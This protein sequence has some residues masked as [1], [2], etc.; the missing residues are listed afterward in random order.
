MVI[1]SLCPWPAVL[2]GGDY[3]SSY[4][5]YNPLYV[6]GPGLNTILRP[7]SHISRVHCPEHSSAPAIDVWLEPNIPNVSLVAVLKSCLEDLNLLVQ[8]IPI[9]LVCQTSM[10]L[11]ISFSLRS[12]EVATWRSARFT[13]LVSGRLSG[14]DDLDI[15]LYD[16]SCYFDIIREKMARF[17]YA[18]R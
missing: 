14:Y 16:N 15:L 6:L 9:C 2:L 18:I 1:N 11:L 12:P 4:T 5:V 3:C 8:V 7:R 10:E 13:G 17:A